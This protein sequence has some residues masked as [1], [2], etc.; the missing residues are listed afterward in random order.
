MG[1]WSPCEHTKYYEPK[2]INIGM[3][4]RWKLGKSWKVV[5]IFVWSN[6]P[7]P[8]SFGLVLRS[9]RNWLVLLSF[10]CEVSLTR[11]LTID[12]SEARKSTAT[13][14]LFV[15]CSADKM[16]KAKYKTCYNAQCLRLRGILTQLPPLIKSLS[17]TIYNN[18]Y[19]K[20]SP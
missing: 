20:L 3:K 8:S 4:A 7:P 12:Q 14:T 11:M 16:A 17:F 1:S 5:N 18:Y 6:Q 19:K 15:S 13:H 2:K 10:L 9:V